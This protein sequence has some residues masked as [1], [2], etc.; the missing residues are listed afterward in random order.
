MMQLVYIQLFLMKLSHLTQHPIS[1]NL[2]TQLTMMMTRRLKK[3][4]TVYK[5]RLLKE[6]MANNVDPDQS[7]PNFGL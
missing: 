6:R 7:A 1:S 4:L 2:R 3:P 5:V